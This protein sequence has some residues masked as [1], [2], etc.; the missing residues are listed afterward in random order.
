MATF[1]V[2]VLV[3]AVANTGLLLLVAWRRIALA[4]TERGKNAR[5]QELRPAVLAFLDSGEALPSG[6]DRRRQEAVADLLGDYAR[7]VRGPA[8]TRIVDYF[9][10]EGIVARELAA[11]TGGRTTSRR[12]VAAQRLGDIASLSAVP[13]LLAALL[14]QQRDVRAAATRSLGRLR[15][16]A[17]V[18]N[19]VLVLVKGDVPA[20]LARWALLQIGTEAVPRLRSLLAS[21]VA[22]Q[23]AAA[24]ELLGLLG[25]AAD[26]GSAEERLH[27]SSAAV[28]EQAALALGRL[29]S[30]HHVARLLSALDDRIPTVRAA[31]ASALGRLRDPVATD[32]LLEHACNDQFD[33]ARAAARAAVLVDPLRAAERAAG[34]GAPHLVEAVEVGQIR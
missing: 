21:D 32:A 5:A 8:H 31:A 1:A 18:E 22:E 12:A 25:G 15:S 7:L 19:I 2:V 26:A 9:E 16:A 10:R 23:R 17:A 30:E 29:G 28:R 24:V 6:L 34:T 13:T 14:D 20:A 4:I 33:V 11:L 3:L 27:D